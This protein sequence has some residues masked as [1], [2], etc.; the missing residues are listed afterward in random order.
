MELKGVWLPVVTP[1][2]NNEVDYESYTKLI[3]YYIDKKISGIIPLGTTGESPTIDDDEFIKIIETTI[4]T[5]NKRIP[6]F[7]G[8]GGNY[9]DGVVRQIRLIEKYDFEGILSVSPYYSRPS[10]AG[11]Y[12]HFRKI[13]DNTDKNIIMYNIPYRTGRNIENETIY[14]LA[15]LKN[16]TGIK[17]SCGDF[18][19]SMELLMNRP[20]NF[21]V[22]T[23]E[24][25][26]FYTTLTLG[27]DGG[28]LAAAHID[29]EK[30]I[31]IY[32]LVKANDHQGAAG[33]WKELAGFIPYLFNEPNPSPLKYMLQKMNLIKSS[34]TRLPL[35][36]ISDDLKTMLDKFLQK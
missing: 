14:K 33:Y 6:V 19:Q 28:I 2:R 17:D 11:I 26:M 5:V 23:G 34:E 13:S 30:Y 12:E 24:D 32:D 31:K 3:E 4:E 35:T 29:T 20:D 1:F 36:G 15:G 22:L 18:K 8:L 7:F 9:T 21:S 25:I 10:Q 16:I 27:G